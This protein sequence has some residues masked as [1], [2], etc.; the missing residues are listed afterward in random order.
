[1]GVH[2]GHQF[3]WRLPE[4]FT[5]DEARAAAKDVEN[6]TR[7]ITQLPDGARPEFAQVKHRDGWTYTLL[8]RVRR[9]MGSPHP[10][11]PAGAIFT[12]EQPVVVPADG[13]IRL[14]WLVADRGGNKQSL[15]EALT[16]KMPPDRATG[17]VLRCQA[18]GDHHPQHANGV[19][20]DLVDA[21][22]GVIYHRFDHGFGSAVRLSTPELGALPDR[23]KSLILAEPGSYAS[24]QL[25]RAEKA[26]APGSAIQEWWELR[27]KVTNVRSTEGNAMPQ[28]QLPAASGFQA[29]SGKQDPAS[30]R[31]T[32]PLRHKLARNVESQMRQLLE[33]RPGH[34]AKPS[35]DDKEITVT[36]P[37]EVM[38]RV[39]TFITVTDWPDT[40]DRGVNFEYPRSTVMVAA[41]AFFYAC[42][43]EDV[44]EAISNLLSLHVL[45]ELKGDEGTS[46]YEH[47]MTGGIPD[48]EWEKSLR[49]DW[50]GKKEALQRL[51]REWNRYPLTRIVEDPGVAVGFGRKHS[52]TVAFDGMAN[53][54][55]HVILEPDRTRND[56]GEESYFFSSLP[57]G[58]RVGSTLRAV[59]AAKLAT[60]PGTY[61]IKPGLK[62]VISEGAD[63]KNPTEKQ[64]AAAELVWE[65]QDDPKLSGTYEISLSDGLPYVVAWRAGSNTLWINGGTTM[66]TGPEEKIIPYLRIL[67]IRGPGDVEVRPVR[68][69][70]L[71]ADP[72][73]QDVHGAVPTNVRRAFEALHD[74]SLLMPP[75]GAAVQ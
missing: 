60:K 45:A 2:G 4:E 7:N 11:A 30:V 43:I 19:L 47:Y 52:C 66:G 10:P 25:L 24:R 21:D 23:N 50:P 5:E 53:G 20:V 12:V 38:T 32:F 6:R 46:Q 48:P 8:A 73:N 33:G 34:E 62:L 14:E 15:G 18:Y 54:D 51:V 29:P 65:W 67:I 9:E 36:A 59:P 26:G 58:W 1:M 56:A 69:D 71:D 61:D 42:A 28:F 70:Q 68:L 27:V 16:F 41:R 40:L 13:L 49:G 63:G 17:F 44:E 57:P 35:A 39:Q 75:S 72:A 31:R 64:S 55:F 74:Q 37:P 3:A 22:T